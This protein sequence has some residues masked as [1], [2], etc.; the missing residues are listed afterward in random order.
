MNFNSKAKVP[1]YSTLFFTAF[2]IVALYDL[3]LRLFSFWHDS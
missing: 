1:L 3:P 2:Q